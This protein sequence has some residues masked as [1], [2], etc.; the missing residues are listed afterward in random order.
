M[1]N[2]NPTVFVYGSLR[3]DEDN[4][5]FL[6]DAEQLADYCYVEGILYDTGLGYPAMTLAHGSKVYGELYRVTPDTLRQLDELEDYH[7]AEQDNDY[8][9]V[10]ETVYM[11]EGRAKAFVYVYPDE[12]A[13]GLK[14]VQSG[15]WRL[16][17]LR[18]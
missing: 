16:Y 7:G 9:R 3:K 11:D 15:D 2:E 17:R 8:L 6:A 18:K 1:I 5:G 4:F 14:R 12:K 10:V 13:K